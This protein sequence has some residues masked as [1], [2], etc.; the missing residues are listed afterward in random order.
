MIITLKRKRVMIFKCPGIIQLL[1]RKAIAAVI[2][3]K[4]EKY[5]MVQECF[6]R[7][8]KAVAGKEKNFVAF[9]C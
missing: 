7:L 6:L 4:E 9:L 1:S 2:Q 3:L 5:L 8:L